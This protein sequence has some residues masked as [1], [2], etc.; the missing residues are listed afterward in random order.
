MHDLFDKGK[1]ERKILQR[2][3][4]KILK[5]ITSDFLKDYDNPSKKINYIKK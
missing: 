2:E 1:R 5:H 3:D 4:S